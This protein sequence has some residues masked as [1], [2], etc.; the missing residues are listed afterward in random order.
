MSAFLLGAKLTPDENFS[1]CRCC[2]SGL[3]LELKSVFPC[4]E[5]NHGW[6]QSDISKKQ[7]IEIGKELTLQVL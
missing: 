3:S 2:R 6:N 4:E 5:R 7:Q 1:V